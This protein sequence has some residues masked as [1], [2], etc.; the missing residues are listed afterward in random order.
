MVLA[1]VGAGYVSARNAI[2]V[3]VIHLSG[4][5]ADLPA[6]AVEEVPRHGAGTTGEPLPRWTTAEVRLDDRVLPAGTQVQV[7]LAAA[8]RADRPHLAFGRGPHHCLGAVL[9]RLEL[10]AAFDAVA[11]GV[12]GMRL[13]VDEDAVPWVRGHVD[14]GPTSVPVTW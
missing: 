6:D 5:F 12:P 14:S 4:R 13:A 1:L 9:A 2:A 10:R 3:G 8:Q 7:S 11:R